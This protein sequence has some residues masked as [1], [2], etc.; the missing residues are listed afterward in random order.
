MDYRSWRPTT[1]HFP[2]HGSTGARRAALHCPGTV[3]GDADRKRL[4]R[5]TLFSI[6]GGDAGGFADLPEACDNTVVIGPPVRLYPTAAPADPAGLPKAEG[7]NEETACAAPP[8]LGSSPGCGAGLQQEEAKTVSRNGSNSSSGD[9]P[10][11]LRR[12]FLIGPTHQWASAQGI[13]SV[14][15]RLGA[16][17]LSPGV[18]IT[19][20]TRSFGLLFERSSTPSGSRC[21]ISTSIRQDRRDE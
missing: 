18:T 4:T 1:V 3:V 21:R 2:D 6:G 12:I 11:G 10:D 14:R 13:R 20:S 17:S 19:I 9:H 7:I 5:I 15:A 8:S 16:G